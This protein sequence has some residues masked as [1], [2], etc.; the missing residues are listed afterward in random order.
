MCPSRRKHPRC[1]DVAR[2][3]PRGGQYRSLLFALFF[4]LLVACAQ[5]EENKARAADAESAAAKQR[6]LNVEKVK[7]RFAHAGSHGCCAPFVDAVVV[8]I[9]VVAVVVA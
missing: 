4:L 6:M 5:L 3:S 9:V 2:R 8:A 1:E 7:L